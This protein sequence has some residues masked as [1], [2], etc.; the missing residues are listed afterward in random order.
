LFAQHTQKAFR[1]PGR[2]FL[3]D[4]LLVFD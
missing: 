4:R 1:Q 3:Y 2:L